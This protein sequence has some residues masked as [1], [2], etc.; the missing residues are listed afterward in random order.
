MNWNIRNLRY[1]DKWRQ[2]VLF[3]FFCQ[4]MNACENTHTYTD[5]RDKYDDLCNFVYLFISNFFGGYLILSLQFK[6]EIHS[7][8]MNEHGPISHQNL[9][10]VLQVVHF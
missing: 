9:K 8:T 5:M 10:D 2:N 3:S 6:R 4:S 1:N 7:P